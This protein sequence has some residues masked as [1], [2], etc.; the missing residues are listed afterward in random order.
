MDTRAEIAR[1][2]E[3]RLGAKTRATPFQH[4]D[5]HRDRGKRH[6]RARGVSPATHPEGKDGKSK[7]GK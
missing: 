3:A 1:H 5:R 4:H 2:A 7:T 6:G